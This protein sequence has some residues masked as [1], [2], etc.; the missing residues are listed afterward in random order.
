M[1]DELHLKNSNKL[2]NKRKYKEEYDN[3]AHFLFKNI[4]NY[5]KLVSLQI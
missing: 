4:K 1:N 3:E 2:T 5:V